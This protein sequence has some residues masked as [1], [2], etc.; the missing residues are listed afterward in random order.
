MSGRP[1][2]GPRE[3]RAVDAVFFDLFGTLLDL[4]AL[5][6]ECEVVAPGRGNELAT[7]WRARQL[8][9]SWLRTMMGT[10]VDFDRVTADALR[11]ALAELALEVPGPALGQLGS[12]F[13]R[14][15]V[16]HDAPGVVSG[17]RASG[18]RSGV[19]T[20]ASRR[21][22]TLVLARTALARMF[23]DALSVDAVGRYKPDPVVYGLAAEAT[24]LDP[25]RIGFVTAN[26]WDAAGAAN[27][28]LRVAWLRG[29]PSAQLP[30]VGA[31]MPLI[32]TWETLH[33][34]LLGEG[35]PR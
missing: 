16:H 3:G 9:T 22:L 1:G 6:D 24:G 10:Y 23:D 20:N 33:D 28:G 7:R 21:T 5:V 8:E 17:L 32:A 15:P 34:V 18:I 30:R 14:L 12:A 27:F 13:Q 29:D 11:I 25:A 4:A 26:G 19:L 35:P 31:L 2:D